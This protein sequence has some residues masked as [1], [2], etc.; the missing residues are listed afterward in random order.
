MAVQI[1]KILRNLRNKRDLRAEM[2]ALAADLATNNFPGRLTVVAPAIS[3]G[4]VQDEWDR[5]L[6]V[7]VPAVRERM[8]LEIEDASDR[9]RAHD[10]RL[11]RAGMVPLARPNYRFEVLRLLIGASLEG[12]GRQPLRGLIE[13]IGASQTPI[14]AALQDLKKAGL[15]SPWTPALELEVVPEDLSLELLA[16]VGALP[17]TLRFRFE[18]GAQITPPDALLQ[19]A[20]PLLQKRGPKDWQAMALSGVP[21]AQKE[22]PQLNLLGLPRLD[23]VAQVGRDVDQ[24]DA[25]LLRKLDDGLELEPNILAAAPVV[26]TV[27]RADAKFSRDAGVAHARCAAAHDVFMALLDQGLRDQAIQYAKGVRP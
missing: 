9:L 12:E 13:K 8:T 17:Q 22:V 23:L 25:T 19:R 5:L 1:H 27:V 14:R 18:R 2:L 24:F 3:P 7:L 6:A 20:L 4:T 11:E 26:V 15:L 10:Y 16:K 21:V